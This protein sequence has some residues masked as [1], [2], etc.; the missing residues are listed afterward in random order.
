MYWSLG[1]GF[2]PPKGGFRCGSVLPRIQQRVKKKNLPG[3][4]PHMQCRARNAKDRIRPV[5]VHVDSREGVR[6]AKGAEA[7]RWGRLRGYGEAGQ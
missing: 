6:D 3:S 1:R 4:R 2:E 7:E 5:R